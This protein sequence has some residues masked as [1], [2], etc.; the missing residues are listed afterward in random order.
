MSSLKYTFG[1]LNIFEAAYYDIGK[2]KKKD[3]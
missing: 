3:A 2:N 1:L